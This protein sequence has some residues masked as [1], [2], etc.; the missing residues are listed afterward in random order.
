MW[1]TATLFVALVV[2]GC[3]GDDPPLECNTQV[4]A[5]CAPLYPPTFENV[6]SM[7]LEPHCGAGARSCHSDSGMKGGM[8][9]DTIDSA[10][11]GLLEPGHDRV[12]PGDPACS[13]MIIRTHAPESSIQMPPGSPLPAAELCALVQWVANGAERMPGAIDAA[14][15]DASLADASIDATIDATIVGAV[16]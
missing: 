12:I 4:S 9:F 13:V 5:A 16:P 6:Y 3:G 7:T 11:A 14:L 15:P 8:T 10:Y 1:P 2:G